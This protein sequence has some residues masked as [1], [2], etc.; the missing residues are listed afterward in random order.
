MSALTCVR[1]IRLTL[2]QMILALFYIREHKPFDTDLKDHRDLPCGASS[3]R[4]RMLMSTQIHYPWQSAYLSAIL[5]FDP[6]KITYRIDQ[7]VRVIEERMIMPVEPG[8]E[9][10]QALEDARLGIAIMKSNN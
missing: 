8:S 6:V 7:A 10:H 5:E 9:E 3:R 4:R 1:Y 2:P